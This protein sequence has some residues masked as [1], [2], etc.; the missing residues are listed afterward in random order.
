MNLPY[1]KGTLNFRDQRCIAKGNVG[2]YKMELE[3]VP[4]TVGD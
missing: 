3:P 1:V 2:I 4:K